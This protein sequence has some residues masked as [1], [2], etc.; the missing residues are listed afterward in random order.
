MTGVSVAMILQAQAITQFT[1]AKSSAVFFSKK[2]HQ[3]WRT[4][5][6]MFPEDDGL[7]PITHPNKQKMQKTKWYIQKYNNEM[8]QYQVWR[9]I[10]TSNMATNQTPSTVHITNKR[11][12]WA[13][14][15]LSWWQA[16]NCWWMSHQV[17]SGHYRSG[18]VKPDW[19]KKRAWYVLNVCAIIP[20]QKKFILS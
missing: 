4:R 12:G 14:K 11:L 19:G 20:F 10:C 15:T 2:R 18:G 13:E 8:L 6:I 3:S 1:M 16:R 17:K 9:M 5:T 7:E